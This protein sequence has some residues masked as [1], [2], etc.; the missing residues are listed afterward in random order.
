[1]LWSS[2]SN[3]TRFML[4][5]LV[6]CFFLCP[7]SLLTL[8]TSLETY[9][10]VF[11]STLPARSNVSV[12]THSP[13][14]RAHLLLPKSKTYSTWNKNSRDRSLEILFQ[15]SCKLKSLSVSV[16]F[17]VENSEFFLTAGLFISHAN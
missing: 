12:H 17:W 4:A 5:W 1:M 3:L 15:S 11:T 13:S 7:D 14:Y 8:A 9:L 2:K 16:W 10:P 6:I